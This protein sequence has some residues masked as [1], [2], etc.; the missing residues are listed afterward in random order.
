MTTFRILKR[1]TS[2]SWGE[3]GCPH[4]TI[5]TDMNEYDWLGPEELLGVFAE[6]HYVREL[7][8]KKSPYVMKEAGIV[9][10]AD[11]ILVTRVPDDTWRELYTFDRDGKVLPRLTFPE[12]LYF[13]ACYSRDNHNGGQKP[14]W[15]PFRTYEECLK[16]I[17]PKPVRPV[18][19]LPA[20]ARAAS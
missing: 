15:M 8:R 14:P 5:I 18:A 19:L 1:I 11:E 20:P 9:R 7:P 17:Y 10:T 12:A 6:L 16:T 13:V 4:W 3:S 2:Y